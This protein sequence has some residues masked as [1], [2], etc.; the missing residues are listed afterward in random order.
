MFLCPKTEKIFYSKKYLKGYLGYSS[1]VEQLPV[2]IGQTARKHDLT[3]KNTVQQS[4]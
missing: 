1:G 4:F 3:F 2:T